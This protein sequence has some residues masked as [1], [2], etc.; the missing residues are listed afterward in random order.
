MWT[1]NT[2]SRNGLENAWALIDS[3]MKD[4]RSLYSIYDRLQ[5]DY[6]EMLTNYRK[7]EAKFIERSI[8]KVVGAITVVDSFLVHLATEMNYIR[9]CKSALER[10]SEEERSAKDGQ[11]SGGK[12]N[13]LV[14]RICKDI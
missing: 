14:H 3:M 5:C 4:G 1:A 8:E 11:R 6:P 13:G 9:K 7:I 12:E 2:G 10:R